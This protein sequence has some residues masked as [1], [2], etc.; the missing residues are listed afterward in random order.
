M[1]G[2]YKSTQLWIDAKFIG[3]INGYRDVNSSIPAEQEF[4]LPLLSKGQHTFT[5]KFKE[6][7][8]IG[9]R[10]ITLIKIPIKIMK[11]LISESTPGFMGEKGKE[12]YPSGNKNIA[13]KKATVLDNGVVLLD[14]QLKPTENCHAFAT[15]DIICENDMQT[16]LRFGA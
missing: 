4:Y 6:E 10:K 2:D 13:W 16:I 5:L 8:T 11:F 12:M 1:N 7:A 14:A 15:T 3:E 9:I